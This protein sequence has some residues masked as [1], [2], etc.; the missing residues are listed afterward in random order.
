MS[1]LRYLEAFRDPD[2]GRS[3]LSALAIAA[4]ALPR[5]PVR[6]MEFCGG[7]TH[8][9]HRFGLLELLPPE[10]RMVHGPGCPVCVLPKG[11]I[12]A[13]I[14]LSLDKNAVL[15]TY[16]DVLRVPGSHGM[17]LM[18][19]RARGAD[20]RIVVSA[21]EALSL[22]EALP[23]REIVFFAIGFETTTPPTAAVILEARRRNLTNF[24]VLAN[25]VLTPPAMEAIL[26]G[27]AL[28]G[29]IGPS[30]VSTVIGTKAYDFVSRKHGIP[31]VVAGFEPL[32]ILLAL[33]ML[34]SQISEGRSEVENEYARAV[35]PE[36]NP[37]S[38]GL[39]ERVFERAP[40]FEWRGLGSLP[41][42]GL[43]IRDEFGIFDA[44][45]RFSVEIGRVSDPGICECGEI[46]K[47]VKGPRDCR[48]FGTL[49][50]PDTPVGAC[51]VSAEG[52]C[53]A[54]FHYGDREGAV[55]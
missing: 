12:D 44:Q 40:S 27:T 23:D 31:L 25:H 43:S 13:A 49:C 51:M 55:S 18:K 7:H 24:S 28:D 32:D 30:H 19:A 10:I 21:M 22:A 53:A 2:L 14:G 3:L 17:T 34:L 15:A 46:L 26:S 39:I 45:R 11:R 47:G 5:A 4:K 37:R 54:V 52:A 42:S 33:R 29:V 16:G 48:I 41:R 9:F 8:A 1:D 6:I 50:T 36:G 38:L 20:V 35:V